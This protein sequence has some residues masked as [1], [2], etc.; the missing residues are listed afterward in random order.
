MRTFGNSVICCL[1]SACGNQITHIGAMRTFS[2]TGKT[3]C[4]LR[5]ST[6]TRVEARLC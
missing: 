4:G 3:L 1:Y 5:T 6:K 2:T